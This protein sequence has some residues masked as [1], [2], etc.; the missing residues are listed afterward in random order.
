MSSTVNSL[1]IPRFPESS[2]LSGEN[3]WR[4]FKDQ[5]L[6]HIEVRELKGYLDGTIIRPPMGGYISTS[7]LYPPATT[8]TPVYSSTPFPHEW[9]Q[10]DRMAASI[11]YLNIVDPVGLGV[12]HEKPAYHIWAELKKKYER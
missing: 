1:S 4:I 9:R 10:R 8:S 3:T 12:E 6:A 5:V 11:I 7:T 2:Q